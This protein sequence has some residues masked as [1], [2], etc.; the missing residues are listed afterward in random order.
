M[1]DSMSPSCGS[2]KEFVKHLQMELSFWLTIHQQ[3]K[4]KM[5]FVLSLKM[6]QLD[7]QRKRGGLG[8]AGLRPICL[9]TVHCLVRD[10]T[11][12]MVLI[13]SDV[14]T[15]PS[16][17]TQECFLSQYGARPR[18]SHAWGFRGLLREAFLK[19]AILGSLQVSQNLGKNREVQVIY[20]PLG[21]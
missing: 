17:E 14:C 6:L 10:Y 9:I 21:T 2:T 16:S 20:I 18:R 3:R 7:G 1:R 4:S 19:V 11:R 12:R 5:C 8:Q 13:E 15:F